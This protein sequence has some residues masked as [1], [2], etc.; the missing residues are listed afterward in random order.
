MINTF[1]K[2]LN[3]LD[4]NIK[5]VIVN[6]A[7]STFVKVAGL[8]SSVFISIFLGRTLGVKGLGIIEL[9]IRISE[10]LLI[11]GVFGFDRV[12]L[13]NISIFLRIKD[14]KQ[15]INYIS[16]S[17]IFNGLSSLIIAV[18]AYLYAPYFCI[19]FFN[20]PELIVPLQ[21]A[22]LV[23]VPQTLSRILA[24]ILNAYGKI[25][26]SNLVNQSLSSWFI[27]IVLIVLH[28]SKIFEINV[29]T[30]ALTYAMARIFVLII[31]FTYWKINFTMNL[32]H[33]KL[34]VKEM[35]V[36]ASSLFLISGTSIIA[37]NTDSIMIGWLSTVGEV[38][39]YVVALKLSI[40]MIFFLQVT[41]SVMAPKLA[42]LY[43][44]KELED[45]QKLVQKVTKGLIFVGF[46]FLLFFFLAG[47]FLL[48]LWGDSDFNSAYPIL[49]VLCVGQFINLSTGCAGMLLI[50]CGFEKI[51]GILSLSAVVLNI[52]LNYFFISLYGG[53]G[54]AYATS[55]TI[56][57][58]NISRVY[59][60]KKYIG[61][62]TIPFKI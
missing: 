48:S 62:Y 34:K 13:K 1:I 5:Y 54:A 30:I 3:L 11:F 19:H 7:K 10:I 40:F 37:A 24:S 33:F 25:W 12:L 22:S 49:M 15:I 50:M 41:N 36:P 45:M 14:S 17:F 29:V 38:G 27:F 43:F 8:A 52:I 46:F 35:F 16:S 58:E 51:Q 9:S 44:L 55:I 32:A 31:V 21:I 59:L 18:F 61:I 42:S 39:I 53:I 20:L 26:Q 60:A 2:K 23:I 57:L 4:K 56:A 47:Y 6:T 28:F